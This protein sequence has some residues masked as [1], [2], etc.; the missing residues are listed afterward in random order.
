[1]KNTVSVLMGSKSDLETV[2]PAVEL[3]KEFGIEPEVKVLSA[4]RTPKELAA[5]VESAPERGVSV[6]IAAAGGSAAL[7]GA[8]AGHTLLP[9]IGIPVETSSL[10][11]VDSLLSTVQMPSGIPVACMAVGAGGAKNAAVFALEILALSDAGIRGK[12]E[13]FRA[14]MREEIGKI[15][16]SL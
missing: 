5:Y 3:L 8:I 2:R 1:M 16:I 4:H 10:R 13:T 11:G 9:V 15:Q 14:K 7:A 6:F 12:M